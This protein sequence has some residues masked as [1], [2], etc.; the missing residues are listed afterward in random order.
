MDGIKIG[1]N[2]TGLYSF[3]HERLASFVQFEEFNSRNLM[4]TY[5]TIGEELMMCRLK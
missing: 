2:T 4:N 1:I 5:E 3:Q